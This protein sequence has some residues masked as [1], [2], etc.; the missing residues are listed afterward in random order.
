MALGKEGGVSEV[1]PLRQLNGQEVAPAELDRGTGHTTH[2]L[3]AW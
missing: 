1:N 3:S 2:A